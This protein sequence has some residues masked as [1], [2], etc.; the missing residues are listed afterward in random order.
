MTGFRLLR[1]SNKWCQRDVNRGLFGNNTEL[2]FCIDREEKRTISRDLCFAVWA[3]C[4]A[5]LEGHSILPLHQ[6][7]RRQT[8]S[9]DY[10]GHFSAFWGKSISNQ[11]PR[12]YIQSGLERNNLEQQWVQ[13]T[14]SRSKLSFIF[15]SLLSSWIQI[16]INLFLLR[17]RYG[18]YVPRSI[19][20]SLACFVE[21]PMPFSTDWRPKWS[22]ISGMKAL[23]SRNL[24]C[25][26][27]LNYSYCAFAL[28]KLTAL[29]PILF[30]VTFGFRTFSSSTSRFSLTI[31][32]LLLICGASRESEIITES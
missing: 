29:D 14:R 5:R 6:S 19:H 12:S 18:L 28:L 22:F 31:L 9:F 30:D 11:S 1:N 2:S 16:R 3:E 32:F 10:H 20:S 25:F 8:L 13:P 17:E 23:S 26:Q 4:T 24:Y 7:S 21:K 15:P 27:D